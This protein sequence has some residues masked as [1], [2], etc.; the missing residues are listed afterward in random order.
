MKVELHNITLGHS[1]LT[2]SVFAGVEKRPGEWKCKQDVT[3]AFIGCVISR[4]ENQTETIAS[5]ENEWEI[6]VKKIK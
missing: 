3:N 5:G 1:D 4:W 2:D 6:T